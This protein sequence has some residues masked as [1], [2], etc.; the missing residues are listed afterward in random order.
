[1][2]WD[3]SIPWDQL[4][5]EQ[6]AQYAQT[7]YAGDPGQ[8]SLKWEENRY[9]LNQGGGQSQAA[10]PPSG[11]LGVPSGGI[12]GGYG[13]QN[14]GAAGPAQPNGS[15]VPPVSAP[16]PV[17]TAP[18]AQGSSGGA[19]SYTA[20]GGSAGTA[21]G[22]PTPAGPGGSVWSQALHASGALQDPRANPIPFDQAPGAASG[23]F[24]PYL[25]NTQGAGTSVSPESGGA[26]T[27]AV[28]P[29]AAPPM[30]GMPASEGMTSYADPR[31][32]MSA[33]MPPPQQGGQ[34]NT[35]GSPAV[36]Q[37]PPIGGQV[38]PVVQSPGST[39]TPE[40]LQLRLA[41]MNKGMGSRYGQF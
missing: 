15:N 36:S 40:E 26:A 17:G 10:A 24:D 37:P 34:G 4:S 39:M 38:A 41:S 11:S 35:S 8:A 33:T 1:M 6:Q 2:E 5:P 28:P 29:V 19:S 13:S 23:A 16:P 18:V 27:S 9:M 12:A 25:R 20:G 31:P 7:A 32:G 14:Y 22:T 21:Q 30:P 3:Y